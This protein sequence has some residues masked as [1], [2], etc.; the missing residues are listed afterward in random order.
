VGELMSSSLV[1]EVGRGPSSGGKAPI[2]LSVR[3]D[4]RHVIGL[5]LGEDCFSGAVV[6]LRGHLLHTANRPLR[7]RDGDTALQIMFDLIESLMAANGKRPLLGIGIGT[8]GVIDSRV[9]TVRWAVNLDWSNLP[10]GAIVAERFGVPVVVANDSQ[11]AALGEMTFVQSPP[12]ANLIVIRVSRGLGAGMILNG[13]LFQG[14]GSGA[15]EIGHTASVPDGELCRCG[16]IGCLETVASMG[17]MVQAAGR[18]DPRIADDRSLIEAFRAGQPEVRRMVIDAGHRLGAA[19]GV[20]I[21]A[22]NVEKIV[23][24]GPA[25]ALGE[26]WLAAVREQAVRSSLPLLARHTHI[27]L[28]HAGDDGVL[29]GASAMLMTRELGLSAVR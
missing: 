7:G 24:V 3:P 18:L 26:D 10:L 15:G 1:E 20:L 29:L 6:D 14:D 17:A 12:P 27:E 4:A 23:L 25:A 28:G 8:P 5:D 11:A 22:L 16:S 9:G 13:Q 2:M 21:G 19:I